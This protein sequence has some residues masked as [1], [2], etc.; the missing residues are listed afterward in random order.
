MQQPQVRREL[1][2]VS[3]RA[4]DRST[5]SDSEVS[6]SEVDE[7]NGPRANILY[8]HKLHRLQMRM[9]S[10]HLFGRVASLSVTYRD[11]SDKSRLILLTCCQGNHAVS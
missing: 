11:N 5:G 6:S 7:K 3:T 1:R 10:L 4:A 8:Y 2:D 9:R